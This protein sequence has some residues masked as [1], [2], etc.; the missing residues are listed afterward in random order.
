MNRLICRIDSA[1]QLDLWIFSARRTFPVNPWAPPPP[2]AD[3][4]SPPPHL[5]RIS[6][7]LSEGRGDGQPPRAVGG[8]RAHP[9]GPP[10]HSGGV[11]G[12]G[13]KYGVVFFLSF[14]VVLTFKKVSFWK[15]R[16]KQTGALKENT[17]VVTGNYCLNKPT[18]FKLYFWSCLARKA[19]KV[20]AGAKREP[21]LPQRG[22]PHCPAC[23]KP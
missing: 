20:S 12:Q 14:V 1:F 8:Q 16:G 7:D 11:T 4:V 21:E 23:L 13:K 19:C 3:L 15:N 5:P 6:P 18:L 9:A 10:K 22:D 17:I 2:P